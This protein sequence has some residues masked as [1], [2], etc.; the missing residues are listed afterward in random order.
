MPDLKTPWRLT[1]GDTLEP[2]SLDYR[3][4]GYWDNICI[5]DCKDGL[6]AGCDEYDV[7]DRKRLPVILKAGEMFEFLQWIQLEPCA[8][9][10]HELELFLASINAELDKENSD[11]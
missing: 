1:K 8:E 10:F 4:P 9:A 3:G 2:V 7:F 5:R 11:A 6:V